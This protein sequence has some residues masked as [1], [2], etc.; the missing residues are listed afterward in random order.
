[1]INGALAGLAGVTG[2]SGNNFKR[3]KNVLFLSLTIKD[4]LILIIY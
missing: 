1:M 4:I 3:F 2:L